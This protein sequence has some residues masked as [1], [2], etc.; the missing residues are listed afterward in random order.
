MEA[1]VQ[2]CLSFIQCH[3]QP[4]REVALSNEPRRWRA[5]TIAR[6]SG[7]GGHA[8]AERLAEFLQTLAPAG[9]PWTVFDR[10]L[11]EQVLA[12]HHLPARLAKFMPEDRVSA[13]QDA[14]DELLGTHPP[15]EKLVHKITETVLRL[16]ELGN[17]ILIGRGATLITSRLNYAFHVRLVGSE[18]KRVRHMQELLPLGEKEAR[19][20]VRAEDRGRRRYTKRYYGRDV[21]DPL[22]YHLMINT[23]LVDYDAAARIIGT[24]MFAQRR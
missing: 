17:V 14:M 22:L 21:D 2:Q 7:S 6:M 20:F 8:V 16:A 15:Q 18:E 10:N 12:D 23:D 19:A 1:G 4:G 11:V 24:A 9:C 13:V 5:V 3:L